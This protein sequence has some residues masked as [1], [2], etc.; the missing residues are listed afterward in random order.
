LDHAVET[1]QRALPHREDWKWAAAHSLIMRHPLDAP[2]LNMPR[3]QRPGD[4]STINAAG[5]T[6]GEAGAS[7]RQIL[8]VGDWDRSVVTN[9]PGE[10]GD[11][12]S[13]HY[14]DLLDDWVAGRYHPLPYSRKA[15]EAAAEEK[16]ILEPK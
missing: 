8:D 5:G 6:S 13:K 12:Q 3:V 15:V 9:A 2:N 7:Y 14:R 4:S 16:I 10:S 1:I 11:P